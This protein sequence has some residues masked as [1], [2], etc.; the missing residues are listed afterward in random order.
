MQDEGSG[1]VVDCGGGVLGEV[2][3]GVDALHDICG[4]VSDG[5]GEAEVLVGSVCVRGVCQWV[6]I[7]C[8]SSSSPCAY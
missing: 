2:R 6:G 4:L 8:F 1:E 7:P 5:F 3:G